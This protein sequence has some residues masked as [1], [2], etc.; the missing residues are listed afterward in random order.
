MSDAMQ[1]TPGGL[2]GVQV[3]VL[4]D[5]PETVDGVRLVRATLA[6]HDTPVTLRIHP[7]S[8]GDVHPY[9]KGDRV[10][11]QPVDGDAMAGLGIVGAYATAPATL[12]R[13]WREIHG[14]RGGGVRLRGGRVRVQAPRVDLEAIDGGTVNVGRADAD[15]PLVCGNLYQSGREDA[16]EAIADALE[17]IATAIGTLKTELVAAATDGDAFV[18]AMNLG[19]A[20]A[21]LTAAIN[22]ATASAA[23]LAAEKA[24]TANHLST[25]VSTSR[26]PA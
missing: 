18:V 20:L 12:G 1:G 3:A 17:A 26:D 22:T 25:Y 24:D 23:T 16:L 14:R 15:E 19:P 21:T 6:P 2:R 8:P 5:D 4:T 13:D 11:V 9:R 10:R 7:Q